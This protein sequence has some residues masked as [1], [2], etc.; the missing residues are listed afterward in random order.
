[1]KEGPYSVRFQTPRGV[2]AGVVFLDGDGK[3]RG[4]DTS[5]WYRGRY[6]DDGGK[7]TAAVAVARHTPGLP[8]VFGVDNVDIT[9]AGTNTDAAAQATGSAAQAPGVSFSVALSRLSD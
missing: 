1:M 5:I 3:L 7:F 4:G 8:S 2:G 6:S 9:L